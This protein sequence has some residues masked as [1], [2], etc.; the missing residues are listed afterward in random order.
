MAVSYKDMIM[1][2]DNVP[3]FEKE[4]VLSYEELMERLVKQKATVPIAH[5]E[6]LS[7]TI[8]KMIPFMMSVKENVE[9]KGYMNEFSYADV[10]DICTK[11]LTFEPIAEEISDD[12]GFDEEDDYLGAF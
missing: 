9:N 7:E 10:V 11:C 4:E 5:E 12:D 2:T 3:H 8:F 1:Q 6:I